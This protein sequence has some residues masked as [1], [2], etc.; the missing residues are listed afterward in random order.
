M[1]SII[2]NQNRNS[3]TPKPTTKIYYVTTETFPTA[4]SIEI[5][6]QNPSFTKHPSVLPTHP[7]N[8]ILAAAK[9]NSRPGFI[10]TDNPLITETKQTPQNFL[11]QYGSTKIKESNC[12]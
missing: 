8:I 4:H 11:K 10:I 1:M 9:L 3:C 2:N 6:E 5:A 12:E 7:H